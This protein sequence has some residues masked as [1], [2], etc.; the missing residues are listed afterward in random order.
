MRQEEKLDTIYEDE[1]ITVSAF[2]VTPIFTTDRPSEEQV[3]NTD[4]ESPNYSTAKAPLGLTADEVRRAAVYY[5]F[6]NNSANTQVH[7]CVNIYILY[8]ALHSS[9]LAGIFGR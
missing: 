5:M 8:Y 7:I 1:N 3:E 9:F 6:R 4:E 2:P